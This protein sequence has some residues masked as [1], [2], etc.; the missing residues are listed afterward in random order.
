MLFAAGTRTPLGD[1]RY[2]CRVIKGG[3]HVPN[4]RL[5]WSAD[6]RT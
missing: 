1:E 4:L 3:F 2:D 6:A 5:S